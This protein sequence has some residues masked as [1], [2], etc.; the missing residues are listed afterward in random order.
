[1]WLISGFMSLDYYTFKAAISTKIPE[2]AQQGA[3][4][5]LVVDSF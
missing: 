3:F 1:M 5:E 2:I 4:A